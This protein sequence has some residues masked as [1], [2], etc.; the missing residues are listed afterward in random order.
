MPKQKHPEAPNATAPSDT[1]AEPEEPYVVHPALAD[2]EGAKPPA[3][4][5]WMTG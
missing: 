1:L 3:L 5:A 4:C 2:I